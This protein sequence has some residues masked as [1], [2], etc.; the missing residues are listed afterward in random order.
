MQ[1]SVVP[2]SAVH[3]M[4]FRSWTD[5]PEMRGLFSCPAESG[6][7]QKVKRELLSGEAPDFFHNPDDKFWGKGFSGAREFHPEAVLRPH[8]GEDLLQCRWDISY[9]MGH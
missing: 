2:P 1:A 7:V 6:L 3:T 9:A 4:V 5:S 8:G